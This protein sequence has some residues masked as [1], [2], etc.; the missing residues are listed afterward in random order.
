MWCCGVLTAHGALSDLLSTGIRTAPIGRTSFLWSSASGSTCQSNH[1]P[2]PSRSTSHLLSVC[3]MSDVQCLSWC[4]SC[5]SVLFTCCM[6]VWQEVKQYYEDHKEMK[7]RAK[8]EEEEMAEQ[9]SAPSKT[10]AI[11]LFIAFRFIPSSL[12]H[13]ASSLWIHSIT[14]TWIHSFISRS[15]EPH[16]KYENTSFRALYSI[17]R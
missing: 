3:L 13:A 7:M 16:S 12:G 9:E 8:Q 1:S 5:L 15:P 2:R 10:P 11:H 14:F 17:Q 4:L 6:C